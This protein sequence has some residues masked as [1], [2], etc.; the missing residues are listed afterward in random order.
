MWLVL[1]RGFAAHP[2]HGKKERW[3][4]GDTQSDRTGK[5]RGISTGVMGEKGSIKTKVCGRFDVERGTRVQENQK[6]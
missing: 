4:G 3:T 5:D 6:G 2:N 1:P